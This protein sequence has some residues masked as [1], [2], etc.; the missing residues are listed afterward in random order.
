LQSEIRGLKSSSRNLLLR[1]AA[2]TVT[3]GALLLP[4]WSVP[5]PP[6]LDYPNQ[7]ARTFIL[8]HLH[9]PAYHF[10]DWYRADWGPF[11]YL[12]MDLTLVSLQRVLPVEVAGKV[13]LSLCLLAVPLSVWWL[14][15]TANPGQ[16]GLAL[17]GL[18]LSYNLF[19]LEGFVN[20]QLGL[21]VCLLT[22]T[23]WIRYLDRPGL[24]RWLLVVAAA[25]A[26]YFAHLMAFIFAGFVIFVYTLV[27]KRRL[28]DQ[29]MAGIPFVPGVLMYVVTGIIHGRHYL[30]ELYFRDWPEKFFDGLAAYRHGYSPTLDSVVLWVTLVAV[31]VAFFRNPE[32][33]LRRSWTI[34]LL[35]C[36]ALYGVLPDEVGGNWEIDTRVIPVGF[37]MLLLVAS[38]GRRQQRILGAIALLL[39]VAR[40]VDVTR[41]FSAKQPELA[42]LAAAVRSIPRD[43][44]VLP[45]I[46]EHNDE[47]A[48][49]RPYVHFWAYSIVERGAHAP[50]L[51]DEPGLTTVRIITRSYIPLRP[52]ADHQPDFDLIRRDYDFVWVY[53]MPEYSQAL[54][55]RGQVADTAGDLTLYRMARQ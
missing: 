41:N 40:L 43:A 12:G 34:V 6:L 24:R 17:W 14:V 53:D 28:R 47:D 18:L 10:A 32:F 54:A 30:G 37:V 23:L 7:L 19:F 52:L 55:D 1:A 49:Q 21:A 35:A 4:V 27:E 45:L 8:S 20:Y 51:F 15:R 42:S 50:Y 44:T 16:G 38:V 13:F 11:P 5:Y 39:F 48:L 36:L 22:I 3:A 2:L 31:I 26:T 9:D 29:L 46:N 25:T 33:R